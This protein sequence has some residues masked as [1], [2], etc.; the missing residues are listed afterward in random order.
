MLS[1]GHVR[2]ITH[3]ALGTFSVRLGGIP[4]GFV[5]PAWG[6]EPESVRD[7]RRSG[8]GFRRLSRFK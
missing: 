6:V 4:G 2:I 1:V 5:V 8:P 7:R 3:I